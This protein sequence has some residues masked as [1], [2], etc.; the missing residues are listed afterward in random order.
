VE[1]G[2]S[3]TGQP[4]APPPSTPGTTPEAALAAPAAGT[5]AASPAKASAAVAGEAPGAGAPAGASLGWTRR[6]PAAVTAPPGG[7]REVLVLAYPV[8]L[9]QISMTTMGIVDS[10][11]VGTLGATHL[12]AVG[13][14]GIWLWTFVCFFIGTTT[15][16]QTFVSQCD[17][18]GDSQQCGS[19]AWQGIYAVAPM[20]LL[21]AAVIFFGAA[22]LLGLLGPSAGL[23]PLAADYLSA[24]S[25][26]IVGLTSAVAFSSF[27]RGIGD[28]RTPLYATLCANGLNVVLDYGLIFGHLGLPR[29][30]IVGA[31]IATSIAE[32]VYMGALLTP[33]LWSRVRASHVTTRSAPI[34]R[35]VRRLLRTGAPIGGQWWLEMVSFAAFTT[36][37]ARMGDQSMAASQAFVALLSISFM[38]A[39]GLSIA[40]STLVG[41]F[42]GA[43][44][45][46]SAMRAFRSGLKLAVVLAGLIA[47]LFSSI[48]E[49]L[50]GIFTD[51]PTVIALGRPLLVVGALFQ[52]LDA[53]GIIADGALRGA[54]DTRWPFLVR[55]ALAWGIFV[56]LAYLMG[57]TLD[58]GL[59]WAWVAATV[60]V[61][62]LSATLV[63]RFRSG[64]WTKIRI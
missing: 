24:R 39:I 37:V 28:T 36:L 54:G 49:L 23:Q 46:E 1:I 9:T 14:G 27:F 20:A 41:Q 32:W 51:D 2:M 56:P 11:M 59:T 34:L 10:A 25:F 50:V 4:T 8:I 35:N 58:G 63:W 53:F 42:I 6:A 55:L 12:A 44:Q 29:L 31:G 61:A 26:G 57:V 16:V 64:A 7:V 62:M 21:A 17:G 22:P 47:V 60:H 38:Q 33:F 43:G 5:A 15:G 52:F 18:A 48:P 19:W 45:P 40:V 3:S 13:F 30:E